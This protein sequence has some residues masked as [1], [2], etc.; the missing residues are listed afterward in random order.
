MPVSRTELN[1]YLNKLLQVDQFKDYCPNGLQVEGSSTIER[2]VTGVTASQRLIEE[3]I[4]HN[5]QAILVHHGYFWK[6]ENPCITGTK[7]SRIATLLQHDIS[8]FAYHLPLDA[9]QRFGNNV[10]FA[11]TMAWTIAGKLGDTLALHGLVEGTETGG[12]LR[13]KLSETLGFEVMHIGEELDDIETIAWCTGAAQGYLEQAIEAGVDAF[14]SGE[15]SEPTV[16][17][18][19]ESGVHY[20]AAGHHATER[21]GVI[22][23]GEH[24]AQHF[25][26]DVQFIDLP[27]PV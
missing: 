3:A 2:L 27:I 15:I 12:S 9:D 6:G 26:L 23:L 7:K 14:V 25:E 11:Q 5:A 18:A 21:G 24:L 8:L 19:R 13:R 22:A 10:Q 4:A 17:L 16:H 1:A 20:F